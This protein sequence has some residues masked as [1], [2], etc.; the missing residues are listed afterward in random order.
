MSHNTA[1]FIAVANE[2][3]LHRSTAGES[4]SLKE[5]TPANSTVWQLIN[6]LSVDGAANSL[7][8]WK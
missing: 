4:T 7:A 3:T 2:V 8:T 6:S 5:P 1:L